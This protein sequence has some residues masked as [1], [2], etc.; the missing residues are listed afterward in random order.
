MT[1][2]YKL[3]I[4]AAQHGFIQRALLA[5]T[6]VAVSCSFLGVFLVLKRFSL[7]GDGLA[8]VSFAA[9][10]FSLLFQTTSIFLSIPVLIIAA[11]LIMKLNEK[12]DLYGD[13]A[14]GLVS[15]FAIALGV[16]AA[17][18]ARGFNVD[19]LSYLFGSILVIG[20]T[21]VAASIILSSL[22]IAIFALFYNNLFALSYDEDFARVIGLKTR[23]LNYMIAVMTAVTISIGIR[24]VG[25]MLI[26]AMIIFPAV[27]ALQ[28]KQG[29]RATIALAA[30]FS[31]LCLIFG[32]FL[33]YILNLPTGSTIVILNSI[34]FIICFVR[35]Q[36]I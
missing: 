33:S 34:V 13:T 31:T 26:S 35:G 14:I 15:S 27:S 21:E 2:F 12:A 6:F 24:V 1:E 19:I 20:T 11:L 25:T 5:G 23:L 3:L 30:L 8:H 16:M 17:S 9:I 28:L 36:F 18:L 10:A 29:F 4:E 32:I 7:I 22:V